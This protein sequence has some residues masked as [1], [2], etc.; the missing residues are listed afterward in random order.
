MTH[1]GS[2]PTP[3]VPQITQQTMDIQS[4][5]SITTPQGTKQKWV[6]YTGSL[7][8][9][10]LQVEKLGDMKQVWIMQIWLMENRIIKVLLT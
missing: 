7:Y 1:N 2:R 5:L 6:L 10:G 3:I 4:N 9:K 8:I